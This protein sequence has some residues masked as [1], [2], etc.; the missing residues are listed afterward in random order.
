LDQYLIDENHSIYDPETCNFGNL[1]RTLEEI[2][3]KNVGRKVEEIQ[4]VI[5]KIVSKDIIEK[6]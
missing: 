3:D 4:K 5:G 2:H 6:L 1:C